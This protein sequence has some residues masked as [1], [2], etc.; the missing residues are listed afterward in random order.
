M[1]KQ[2]ALRAYQAASKRPDF[3]LG[4]LLTATRHYAQE[5]TGEDERFTKHPATFLNDDRWRDHISPPERRT[6]NDVPRDCIG[7]PLTAP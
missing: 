5:R 6:D 2:T 1:H 3:S 4:D 7:R